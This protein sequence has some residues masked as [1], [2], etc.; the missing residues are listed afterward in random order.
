MDLVLDLAPGAED[1]AL[2]RGIIERISKNSAR[3]PSCAA[4]FATMQGSVALVLVDE[5]STLTLRFDRGRLT[6][7]DGLIGVPT[8]S[9]RGTKD[10]LRELSQ[11]RPGF[12]L[13]R[14]AW[15]NI[16]QLKALI[17][18]LVETLRSK[19]II[20]YGL[21]THPRL[22]LQLLKVVGQPQTTKELSDR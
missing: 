15:Q 17:E 7:H 16:G 13:N 6:I 4:T 9:I 12:A 5:A 21:W 19:N 14:N 20:A 3:D 22:A 10:A 1:S 11:L 2:A 18:N 8:L